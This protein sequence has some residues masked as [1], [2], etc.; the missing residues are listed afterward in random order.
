MPDR[1]HE[2]PPADTPSGYVSSYQGLLAKN[3]NCT[4][5]LFAAK[6]PAPP[7]GSDPSSWNPDPANDLCDLAPGPR[8]HDRVFYAHIGGVPHELLQNDPSLSDAQSQSQKEKLTDGD[9]TRILGND[10][11][12]YDYSGIDPHMVESYQPRTGAMM[13]VNGFKVAAASQPEGTDPIAGREWETD[14]TQPAHRGQNVDR[15]YACIFKLTDDTGKATPRDCSDASVTANPALGESCDCQ[16]PKSGTLSHSQVPGVCNDANPTQQDSAK[17]YPTIRELLLAKLLGKV[18][19]SNVGIVSSLCPI[20]TTPTTPDGKPD[21]LFGYR[22][23]MNAI[24]TALSHQLSTQCLPERLPT[25]ID[26]TTQK[27]GVPC[28][29]LGTFPSG[30]GAPTDCASVPG[31]GYV[32]VDPT[33]LA[34]FQQDQHGA[35]READPN[36]R[37]AVDPSTELTCAA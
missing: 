11:E 10:P 4:N 35:V 2:Y 17:A 12:N 14:S 7:S 1:D 16:A 18:D 31:G 19:G 21:P 13:P 26:P 28:L 34:H 22:P 8:P 15:E 5:P 9:W 37:R 30:P 23:A 32:N 25:T 33:V 24:V 3:L 20:H 36:I 27:P 29:V 6:L